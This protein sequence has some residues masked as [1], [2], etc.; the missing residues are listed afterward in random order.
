MPFFTVF[1]PCFI[2][3][4]VNY[5]QIQVYECSKE[6]RIG[7]LT[8][9]FLNARDG[10]HNVR[11][12]LVLHRPKRSED[13]TTS[14]GRR[15]CTDRSEAETSNLGFVSARAHEKKKGPVSWPILFLFLEHETGFE[16]ATLALARRYSTTEPLV[17]FDV[18][19]IDKTYYTPISLICQ[20]KIKSLNF[21]YNSQDKF[22]LTLH[23]FRHMLQ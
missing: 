8:N 14:G 4:T 5:F 12:T 23:F 21:L 19:L 20:Q 3:I 10:V 18:S 15:Y 6:K 7:F 2:N 17:H 13:C 1:L 9:P 16:P 11:W 22:L